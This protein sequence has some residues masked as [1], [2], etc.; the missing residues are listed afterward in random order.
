MNKYNVC[1]EYLGKKI[2]ITV[3]AISRKDA[4]HKAIKKAREE[5]QMPNAKVFTMQRLLSSK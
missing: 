3:Q 5:M 2:N 1:F 4:R